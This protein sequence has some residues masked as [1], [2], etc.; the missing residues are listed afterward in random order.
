M[1][2]SAKVILKKR[3]IISES[4]RKQQSSKI[5]RSFEI[6]SNY[7]YTDRIKDKMN[8]HSCN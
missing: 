2:N 8:K 4:M 5:T 1:K 7:K 3:R 6:M